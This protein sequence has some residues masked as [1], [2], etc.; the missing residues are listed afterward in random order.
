M[1]VAA[2]RKVLPDFMNI[3]AALW[4][5]GTT[6]GATDRYR[7]SDFSKPAIFLKWRGVRL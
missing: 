5:N 2:N 4:V 6:C 1:A 3:V 7:T